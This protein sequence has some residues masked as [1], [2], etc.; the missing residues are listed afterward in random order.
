MF[1]NPETM[2]DAT[3]AAY[4]RVGLEA[5]VLR[6]DDA[7]AWALKIVD[8]LEIPPCEIVEVLASRTFLG[9]IDSLNA[10]PGDRDLESAGR[11]LLG[12]LGRNLQDGEG[13]IHAFVRKAMRIVRSANLGDEDYYAFD[14]IEDGLYLAESGT[15]G[16]VD[17]CRRDLIAAFARCSQPAA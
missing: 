4:L 8:S 2:T 17:D 7:K 15:Y 16:T 1:A 14:A 9:L 10:V 13:G 12:L 3:M 11:M 6:E 5:G